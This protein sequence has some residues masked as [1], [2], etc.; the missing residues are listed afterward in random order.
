M[1]EGDL[2]HLIQAGDVKG[3]AAL[4]EKGI[5]PILADAG[6]NTPLDVAE[7]TQNKAMIDTIVRI[8]AGTTIMSH[9]DVAIADWA[10]DSVENIFWWLKGH[11]CRCKK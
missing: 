9:Y 8:T 1:I 11:G 4:L 5:S 6:G 2:A 7:A 10:Q 3:A